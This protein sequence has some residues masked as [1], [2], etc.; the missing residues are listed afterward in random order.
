MKH[1]KVY[2]HFCIKIAFDYQ[3]WSMQEDEDN[4]YYGMSSLFPKKPTNLVH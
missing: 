1:K 4:I 2:L 3:Q